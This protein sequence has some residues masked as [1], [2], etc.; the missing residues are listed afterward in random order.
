MQDPQARVCFD[1]LVEE[2]H[3]VLRTFIRMLGVQPGWVDDVAQ[4]VF[5]IAHRRFT[6][7]DPGQGPFI[8]WIR[9][10]ARRVVAN[11]HRGAGRRMRVMRSSALAE[12]LARSEES[13]PADA[14]VRGELHHALTSCLEQLP[15]HGRSLIRMRYQDDL[16][17]ETMGKEVGRDAN[18]VRQSL[19]RLRDILR[20][21]IDGRM[22]GMAW[23]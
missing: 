9:G 18:A 11:E 20:R 23:P 12:V 4:E 16:D 7:F 14:L 17:A 10:I 2:H 3:L 21:C 19:F 13:Q 22:D 1:A 15:E 8:A 5:L 6:E